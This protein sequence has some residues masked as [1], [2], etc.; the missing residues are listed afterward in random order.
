MF[1]SPFFP[2]LFQVG[3][4]PK[5]FAYGWCVLPVRTLPQTPRESPQRKVNHL[6]RRLIVLPYIP[7]RFAYVA[8]LRCPILSR[9][10]KGDSGAMLFD[11]SF[12]LF[13]LAFCEKTVN[14]QTFA[15]VVM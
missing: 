5:A 6:L 15:I 3:V 11:S 8:H 7:A 12:N 10:S 2:I 1:P 13:I 9:G 14:V 4:T